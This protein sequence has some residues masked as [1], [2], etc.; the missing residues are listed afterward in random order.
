MT[1]TKE[2]ILNAVGKM[3]VFELNDLVQEFSEKFGVSAAALA[4][5]GPAGDGATA[6]VEEEQTEFTVVL[7]EAGSNRVA[8]IKA[9]R[10][11]INNL[12][13]KEAKDLIDSAPKPVKESV[14]KDEAEKIKKKLETAGAKIEVK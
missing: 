6:P 12:S 14:S 10:E 5:A 11:L 3:T 13:L 8:V 1:Q 7:L 4:V 2:D 9:V